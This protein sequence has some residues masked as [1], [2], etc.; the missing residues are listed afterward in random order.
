MAPQIHQ[1]QI[2]GTHWDPRQVSLRRAGRV[3]SLSKFAGSP[4]AH[5]ESVA[6]KMYVDTL[7]SLIPRRW[8]PAELLE[9][10][11][12]KVKKE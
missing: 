2:A 11:P 9:S 1:G 7:K 5:N 8:A 4:K 6:S 10:L 3:Y 12:C